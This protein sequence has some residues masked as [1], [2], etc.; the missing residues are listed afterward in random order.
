M[1]FCVR[2]LVFTLCNA[3]NEEKL[4]KFASH[5]GIAAGELEKFDIRLG[6]INCDLHKSMEL[7]SKPK[8]DLFLYGFRLIIITNYVMV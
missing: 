3:E 8:A 7:C 5:Y 6:Q 2:L 1:I 4:S